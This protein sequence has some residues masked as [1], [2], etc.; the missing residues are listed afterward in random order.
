MRA[1]GQW[2]RLARVRFLT[3][4]FWRKDSRRRRA[5]GELRL[6]MVPAATAPS[7]SGSFA[8]SSARTG[9]DRWPSVGSGIKLNRPGESEAVPPRRDGEPPG[10]W[11]IR[12]ADHVAEVGSVRFR[13]RGTHA[14]I[15]H[16]S[17]WT[18]SN[19]RPRCLETSHPDEIRTE[20]CRYEKSPALHFWL[21]QDTSALDEMAGFQSAPPSLSVTLL[22]ATRRLRLLKRQRR[23]SKHRVGS[24]RLHHA[25]LSVETSKLR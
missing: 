23:P 24:L 21:N 11:I 17:L 9:E 8:Q 18:S 6:G 7:P 16:F 3:L 1:A 13:T 12:W 20:L 19:D 15:L 5:G 25:I 4:P 2:E 14:P 22:K 10:R